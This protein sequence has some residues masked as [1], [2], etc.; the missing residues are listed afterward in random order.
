LSDFVRFCPIFFFAVINEWNN[1]AITIKHEFMK[2]SILILAIISSVV[3]SSAQVYRHFL[4]TDLEKSYV[5][6]SEW[7]QKIREREIEFEQYF[8]NQYLLFEKDDLATKDVQIVFNILQTSDKKVSFEQ[9]KAQINALNAAFNNDLKMPDDD[10][11]KDK[12]YSAGIRFCVP[13]YTEKYIRVLNFPKGTEF[14]D[15]FSERG[16]KGIEPFEPERYIN[17]WV[18]DLGLYN[19]TG[20]QEFAIAGYAQLPLRDPL[21]DGIIIDIDHFG[22]QP[23]NELYDKGLTLAHL[24]G[25]YLGLRPLWGLEGEGQCGGD[26]VDDT[27]THAAQA[28][29]CL[30]QTENQVVGSSCWGNERMMNKNFMDNIPDDCAAMFTLGQ[31]RKMHG[32]LGRKGPRSGLIPEISLGCDSGS[33]SVVEENSYNNRSVINVMPN[34]SSDL[35]NVSLKLGGDSKQVEYKYIVYNLQGQPKSTG[36]I[37]NNT[38]EI[39]VED[40]ASGIYYIV[41]FDDKNPG[42]HRHTSKFEVVK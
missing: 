3:N 17:I 40:W 5:D 24:M 37:Q 26:G 22:L 32:N 27:P 15:L 19:P 21:K 18:A 23:S 31:R 35:I 12:A 11:Y 1:F 16:D 4:S 9:I 28:L 38:T 29:I 34:P 33:P 36:I 30:P 20:T 39:N 13:E 10:Y 41:V 14:K 2:Y 25:I 7:K 6:N 42:T 8:Q